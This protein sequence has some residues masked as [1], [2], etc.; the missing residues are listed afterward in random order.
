MKM[1]NDAKSITLDSIVSTTSILFVGLYIASFQ[2]GLISYI[3]SEL[4]RAP[5]IK[6]I[7]FIIYDFVVLTAA[8]GILSSTRHKRLFISLIIFVAFSFIPLIF[9][10]SEIGPVTKSYVVSL[11]SMLFISVA[12]CCGGI[13]RLAQF[14]A[15]ITCL[16]SIA[17]L[18]DVCFSDGFSNTAGRAAS[19]YINPNVAALALLLGAAASTWSVP[20]RWRP[21]YIVLVAGAIVTTLSRSAIVMGSMT[22]IACIP[23]LIHDRQTALVEIRAGMGR[24]LASFVLVAAFISSALNSNHAFDVATHDSFLGVQTALSWL[25]VGTSIVV[26]NQKTAADG[27]G[28]DVVAGGESAPRPAAAVQDMGKAIAITE[29][30]NSAATRGLLAWRS[31]LQFRNAPM[32]GIGLERAFALAPHNTYLLFAVAFGYY[33]WLIVPSLAAL[34][35]FL[36][37][38]RRGLP[39]ATLVVMAAFFSH[40]SLFALPLISPL[41]IILASSSTSPKVAAVERYITNPNIFLALIASLIVVACSFGYISER[42]KVWSYETDITSDKIQPLGGYA[43]YAPLLPARPRG[44]V[45]LS[46]QDASGTSGIILTESGT[47]LEAG[48]N[49]VDKIQSLGHG[50]YGFDNMWL[51][52]SSSDGSDASA[53]GKLYHLS[54]QVIIHPLFFLTVLATVIWAT[55]WIFC[56]AAGVVN[57]SHMRKKTILTDVPGISSR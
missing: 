48:N 5:Q 27:Q 47:P 30:N 13:R 1:A 56:A 22:L 23:A 17:C 3:S 51:L 20:Y 16:A 26:D 36:S 45:R 15:S 28:K 2:S 24:A 37:G 6:H 34:I 53:N 9:P 29:A 38:W 39:S 55:C 18:L 54:A 31:W 35:L 44:L 41:V 52:F 46:A 7:I 11:A 19:L 43:F 33:G 4:G 8:A 42:D 50:R 57:R 25:K 40:D 49:A 12:A 14:S 10:N 21:A 32:T